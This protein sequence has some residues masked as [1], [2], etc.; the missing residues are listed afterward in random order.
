MGA[1]TKKQERRLAERRKQ[2]GQR[3]REG[4]GKSKYAVKRGTWRE[5]ATWWFCRGEA[6]GAAS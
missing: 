6:D 4:G 5:A 2:R 3:Q 1:R